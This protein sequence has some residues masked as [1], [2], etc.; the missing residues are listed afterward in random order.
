MKWIMTALL[1][2]SGLLCCFNFYLSFLR[3]PIHRMMGKKKEEYRWAS[4]IPV[5]GSLFVA[6][7]LLSFWQV[8]WLRGTAIGL[9]LI[10]TGGLHWFAGTMLWHEVLKKR[11]RPTTGAVRR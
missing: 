2:F 10:D 11:N 1:V 4:G 3:Y 5:F 6:I 9:I 7:S 8:P